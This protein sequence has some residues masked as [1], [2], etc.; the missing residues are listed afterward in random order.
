MKVNK[1]T[2]MA[3]PGE[4]P[5]NWYVVDAS[6][7]VLGRLATKVATLLIGKGKPTFTPHVLSGDFVIVT[8]AK[9]VALTGDKWNQKM[10]KS[11]TGYPGGLRQRSAREMRERKPEYII[12]EAVRRMLPK[13][14]MGRKIM[15]RLKV[16]AGTEHPHAAQE[17]KP[18]EL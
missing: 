2:F 15:T 17:P 8:N 16:Y 10:Y 9:L 12:E 18:L 13:G 1:T 4:I 5:A 7:K 6:E 14:R 11:Y 3:K